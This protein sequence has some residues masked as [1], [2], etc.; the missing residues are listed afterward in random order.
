[1]SEPSGVEHGP[2]SPESREHARPQRWAAV[3]IPREDMRQLRDAGVTTVDAQFLA[4]DANIPQGGEQGLKG[5]GD[6]V[7][8]VPELGLYAVFDGVS[9]QTDTDVGIH[10]AQEILIREIR[11]LPSHETDAD[12]IRVAVERAV[13]LAEQAL[14]TEQRRRTSAQESPLGRST[15]ALTLIRAEHIF[16]IGKGDSPIRLFQPHAPE[17]ERLKRLTTHNDLTQKLFSGNPGVVQW[18]HDVF[19]AIAGI[20][21]IP[22]G[23]QL[24]KPNVEL[25]REAWETSKRVGQKRSAPLIENILRIVEASGN[26]LTPEQSTEVVWNLARVRAIIYGGLGSGKTEVQMQPFGPDDVA[27]LESDAFGALTTAENEELLETC[28]DPQ[29]FATASVGKV[30]EKLTTNNWRASGDDTTR[31]IIKG[32]TATDALLD[33]STQIR[34][35][36][37][38]INLSPLRLDVRP[39]LKTIE[40][41]QQ[42]RPYEAVR[43]ACELLHEVQTVQRELESPASAP[44][45]PPGDG[46]REQSPQEA[47]RRVVETMAHE[48]WQGVGRSLAEQPRLLPTDGFGVIA[49]VDNPV[50]PAD[51]LYFFRRANT[52]TALPTELPE[53]VVGSLSGHIVHE[54]IFTDANARENHQTESIPLV[55]K[56]GAWHVDHRSEIFRTYLPVFHANNWFHIDSVALGQWL[57]FAEITGYEGEFI[58]AQMLRLEDGP[59]Y[60]FGKLTDNEPAEII[61]IP[62]QPANKT[63]TAHFAIVSEVIRDDRGNERPRNS[64]YRAEQV[65]GEVQ[66]QGTKGREYQEVLQPFFRRG[67]RIV[68]PEIVRGWE[69][70]LVT[71]SYFDAAHLTIAQVTVPGRGDYYFAANAPTINPTPPQ[72]PEGATVDM[73]FYRRSRYVSPDSELIGRLKPV[74]FRDEQPEP[75][76]YRSIME[77]ASKKPEDQFELDVESILNDH[78]CAWIRCPETLVRTW[79]TVLTTSF[80][81]D[82]L[83]RLGVPLQNLAILS[84]TNPLDLDHPLLFIS[85]RPDREDMGFVPQLEMRATI[86][87]VGQN[88]EGF[89]TLVPEDTFVSQAQTEDNDH[90][91]ENLPPHRVSRTTLPFRERDDAPGPISSGVVATVTPPTPPEQKSWFRSKWGRRISRGLGIAAG[92]LGLRAE[93][94]D[95]GSFELPSK[96]EPVKEVRYTPPPAEDAGYQL[97]DATVVVRDVEPGPADATPPDAQQRIADAGIQDAARAAA[98]DFAV[99]DTGVETKIQETK[100]EPLRETPESPE[101]PEIQQHE[102]TIRP[103]E[104]G[105]QVAVTRALRDQGVP[106]GIAIHAV[107]EAARI[108]HDTK[109]PLSN[110][111][112]V[113]DKIHFASYA[114]N[115]RLKVR[116]GEVERLADIKKTKE[117]KKQT[118][119]PKPHVQAETQTE[120]P[121]EWHDGETFH[122]DS[123]GQQREFTVGDEV[124]YT[125]AKSGLTSEY[126]V[127][128]PSLD[129][130]PGLILQVKG[131]KRQFALT[132]SGAERVMKKADLE[133]DY[134]ENWMMV[135]DEEA[136]AHVDAEGNTLLGKRRVLFNSPDGKPTGKS[137][138]QALKRLIATERGIALDEATPETTVAIRG[139]DMKGDP[140]EFL[141]GQGFVYDLDKEELTI[142][143]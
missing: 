13:E 142:I 128:G 50:D 80:N 76:D 51:H 5:G 112:F 121:K 79:E 83:R 12:V 22:A 54:R 37:A 14:Q 65:N 116:I 18:I 68:S 21:D 113:G 114:E 36:I 53:H 122:I 26:L 94:G 40:T 47:Y 72:L 84:V 126:K 93:R 62:G 55:L 101:T 78:Q 66:V 1:M 98:P 135:A 67:W 89:V 133:Q 138:T 143:R 123:G 105:I 61:D 3:S 87:R 132:R 73:R 52:L 129:K 15:I 41:Y 43:V 99:P 103:F 30:L 131:T 24:P 33:Y 9:T 81:Y 42:T 2:H 59:P 48:G 86:Y 92:V 115:G 106:E 77:H 34:N 19:D 75:T 119:E 45:P 20:N 118:S 88:K 96:P 39:Y 134:T 109:D 74:Q 110:D 57:K 139:A 108:R 127:L 25:V 8:Y 136:K 140:N 124:Y 27:I 63:N 64:L 102:V 90:T 38:A 95:A 4:Q 46:S 29:E 31:E 85:F 104:P 17:G 70:S 60:Y 125:S 91:I 56:D 6:A 28:D 44:P 7:L 82:H 97:H 69:T 111:V 117:A 32:R 16:Y 137:L 130:D 100:K 58:T 71:E 120:V 141:L 35:I 11:T 10:I 107:N 23:V 49:R